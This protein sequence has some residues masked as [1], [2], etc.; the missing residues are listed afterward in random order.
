MLGHLFLAPF[1]NTTHLITSFRSF[2]AW[3]LKIFPFRA[4]SR[5]V[6]SLN[7]TFPRGKFQINFF[8]SPMPPGN[9]AFR[10]LRLFPAVA[11]P[12]PPSGDG[13]Y[14]LWIMGRRRGWHASGF[15]CR[16]P[17]PGRLRQAIALGARTFGENDAS[18]AIPACFCFPV[19]YQPLPLPGP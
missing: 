4:G 10:F 9:A 14:H 6:D 15:Y 16:P 8:T 11:R 1:D 7:Y 19:H 2:P 13:I 3:L 12:A 18:R 5:P 17:K